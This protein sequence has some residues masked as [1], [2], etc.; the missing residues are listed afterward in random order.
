[1]S[2]SEIRS[3]V[4]RVDGIACESPHDGRDLNGA[5]SMRALPWGMNGRDGVS[6]SEIRSAV[7]CMHEMSGNSSHEASEPNW[8]RILRAHPLD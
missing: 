6:L 1:M 7:G 8:A 5:R 4:W 3:A 2:P